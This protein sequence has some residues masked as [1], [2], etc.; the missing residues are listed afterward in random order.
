MIRY[1]QNSSF[2]FEE[3]LDLYASVEWTNYTNS[4]T[5]LRHSLENS[6]FVLSVYD[7]SELVGLIRL[8]GDGHSIVFVQDILVKPTYQRRGI[9]TQLMKRALVHFPKVYQLHLLTDQSEKTASF[10]ESMGFK[11][12]EEVACRAFTLVKREEKTDLT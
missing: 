11:A 2:S 4:A 6:L 1:S 3:I 5:M 12:V 8:V 10:Y 7:Q 9:G